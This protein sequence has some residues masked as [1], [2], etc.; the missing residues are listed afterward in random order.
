M[1]ESSI[2]M[3]N[4]H[5][6]DNLGEIQCDFC[7]LSFIFFDGWAWETSAAPGKC[8]A[9]SESRQEIGGMIGLWCPAAGTGWSCSARAEGSSSGE[10]Q[11]PSPLE[12]ARGA[13]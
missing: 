4:C 8:S 12:M 13:A 9:F 1:C 10:G 5:N 6:A 3:G 2:K 7:E 11:H